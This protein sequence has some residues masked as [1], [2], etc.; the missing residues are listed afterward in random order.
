MSV[1]ASRT[2]LAYGFNNPLQPLYPLPII[3]RRAPTSTDTAEFGTQWI[4]NNSIWEYTSAQTW[5]LIA[6]QSANLVAVSG[7]FAITNNAH[8]G[9]ISLTGNTIAQSATQVI[10]F[11]NSNITTSN[12]VLFSVTSTNTSGNNALLT[13]KGTVQSAGALA[14]SVT[15]NGG[16]SGLGSTDK[17]IISFMVLG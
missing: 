17:I 15:N 16:A 6:T 7:A 12:A 2:N 9:I 14:I 8:E 1:N 3:A 11:S 10:T 5:T 13:V 4:Y